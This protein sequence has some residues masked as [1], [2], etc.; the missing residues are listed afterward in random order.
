M[1]YANADLP[2]IEKALPQS[3][4]LSC[5]IPGLLMAEA[6]IPQAE[7]GDRLQ[8]I[9]AQTFAALLLPLPGDLNAPSCKSLLGHLNQ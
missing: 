6:P 5:L 4:P 3:V 8:H 7:Q 2:S 1:A 9:Q